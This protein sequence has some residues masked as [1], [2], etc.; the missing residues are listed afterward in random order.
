MKLGDLGGADHRP[1]G[2]CRE[3]GQGGKRY[4]TGRGGN[5]NR[6]AG[7]SPGL[8]RVLPLSPAR[9]LL[10]GG[11]FGS[12]FPAAGVAD[13]TDRAAPNKGGGKENQYG[14]QYQD[15]WREFH[16][17]NPPSYFFPLSG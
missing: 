16:S 10:F 5:Q 12:L 6:K 8:K 7:V 4:L 13:A 1:G 14:N 9:Y 3:G 11:C 15:G 2:G 17:R